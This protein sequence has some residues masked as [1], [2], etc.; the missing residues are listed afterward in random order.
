M[1]MIKVTFQLIFF[2][3]LNMLSVGTANANNV[4]ADSLLKLT[5][6]M[7]L[8]TSV[9]TANT[10]TAYLAIGQGTTGT[11][12]SAIA[13]LYDGDKLLG[14]NLSNFGEIAEFPF[15]FYWTQTNSSFNQPR[16]T[17]ID[18]STLINRSI[19]GTVLIAFNGTFD[20]SNLYF[21]VGNG[22][23]GTIAIEGGN[24]VIVDSINVIPVPESSSLAMLLTG[25]GMLGFMVRLRKSR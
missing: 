25:L 1:K 23:N 3:I 16:T 9:L 21:G 7:P 13:S 19:A 2:S 22:F 4:G 17:E 12:T 18:A 8:A 24:Q 14:S 15:Y 10:D 6:H 11:A 20:F 5:F